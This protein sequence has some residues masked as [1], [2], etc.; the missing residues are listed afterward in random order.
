[1]A[2]REHGTNFLN[3][4]D[5]ETLDGWKMAGKGNFIILQKENALQTQG[6]MGLLWYYK[7]KFKDFA[8]ELEWKASS[9]EDNSGIFVRF[10]NPRNDP[11]V[12][13]TNGYEIQIDDLA[14]PNGNLIHGPGAV[15]N[16]AAPYTINSKSIGEWNS[17]QIVVEK[18]K[19]M[20]ITN[21]VTVISNFTGNRLL[22]GYIGLQNHDDNSKVFFRNVKIRETL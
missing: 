15:Y 11:Y 5:G 17:L 3:L 21:G 20:V 8:L 16:F 4:F 14:G 13:V 7:K 22:E 10:P 1:M 2:R 12:A 18:Q 6:G 9:K 19:Y